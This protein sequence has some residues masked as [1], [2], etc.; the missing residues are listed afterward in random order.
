M[1]RTLAILALILLF[2][3]LFYETGAGLNT[4]LFSP[5]VVGALAWTS[6]EKLRRSILRWILG[7]WVLSAVAVTIH[8]SLL[9]EVVYW[10]SFVLSWGYL[11][12]FPKHFWLF[13]LVESM[14]SFFTGWWH[15]LRALLWRPDR[16]VSSLNSSGIWRQLRLVGIPSL[17]LLPFYLLYHQANTSFQRVGPWL[18]DWLA[19]ILELDVAGA[20]LVHLL[21]ATMVVTAT[22]GHRQGYPLLVRL[23][24]RWRYKLRRQRRPGSV[25]RGLNGLRTEYRIAIASFGALNALLL[26]INLLDIATV[27]FQTQNRTA[28]ELSQDVHQGTWLLILSILLAIGVV[29]VFLRGN[30]NFYPRVRPLRQLIYLWL[31]QNAFL[32]LSVGM[33]NGQYIEAYHLAHGRIV[34]FF[35]LALCLYGL[36]SV[37]QKVKGPRTTFFLLQRNGWAIAVALL[38]S[39]AVNWD[40]F[41]TSYNLRNGSADHYYLGSLQNNLAPILAHWPNATTAERAHWNST[42]DLASRCQGAIRTYEASDWRSWNYRDY[43]QYRLA[44]DWLASS[45]SR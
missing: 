29:V 35:F 14:A 34:V 38:L 8:H 3:G 13:G 25:A 40:S 10:L 27:W 7:G 6:P 36:H 23:E 20:A 21:L 9:S 30:L 43:H 15:S 2:Q 28:A 18:A 4:L 5:A 1:K 33:R 16:P 17:L 24:R 26:L 31:G 45:T 12:A 39:S 37:Y 41:I 32:A 22:L 44:K 42:Y 11:V 19:P